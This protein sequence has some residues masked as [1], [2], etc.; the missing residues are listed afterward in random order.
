MVA[1]GVAASLYFG[2][3]VVDR[4]NLN[5][6]PALLAIVNDPNSPRVG[7]ADATVT[8]L[9]FTDY[10]C[11]ICRATD[12]ALERLAA[13]DRRVRIIFKD[14]P[15]LGANSTLAARAALAA[16]RQGKYLSL[17]Q[18]LMTTRLPITAGTLK[19]VAVGAGVDWPRLE[20]DLRVYG[21]RID[22]TLAGHAQQSRSL[23]LQGTPAYI[24]GST[25]FRGGLDGGAL[26]RAVREA[27]IA[28]KV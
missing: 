2:R 3:P 7:P 28:G 14:W 5:P 4:Q 1:L 10:Q 12:P 11:P 21:A 15:I 17:H 20:A 13:S 8:I 22:Q 19:R 25:L 6:T 26:A 24:V 18:A 23:G 27:R 9:V 16:D